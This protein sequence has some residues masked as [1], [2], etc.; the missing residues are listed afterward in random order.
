MPER[1]YIVQVGHV[2]SAGYLLL[3][4]SKRIDRLDDPNSFPTAGLP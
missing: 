4:N 3:G 2:I 1:S